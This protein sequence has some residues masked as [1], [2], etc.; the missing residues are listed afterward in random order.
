MVEYEGS[1]ALVSRSIL[2]LVASQYFEEIICL[3]K[4]IRLK[5]GKHVQKSSYRACLETE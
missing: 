3:R 4:K 5:G 1:R 2:E